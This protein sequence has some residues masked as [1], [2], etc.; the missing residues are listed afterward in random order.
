MR[1][2]VFCC[3]VEGS[4][5][6]RTEAVEALVLEVIDR[7]AREGVARAELE[8]V[9]HQLELHQREVGGDGFPFGLSLILQALGCA[10]HYADPLQVLD[11]DPVLA[12]LRERIADP[13]YIRGLARRLLLDNTHRITLT[14]RPDTGLSAQRREREKAELAALRERLDESAREQLLARAEALKARQA[15]VDD[16]DVLPRVTLADVPQTL[17]QLPYQ[18]Q[19]AGGLR[20][21]S[22]EQGTNGLVY[23]QLVT[24][25]PA[26]SDADWELLSHYTSLA[27]ELGVGG[28]GYLET[29]QRQSAT[30]GGIQLA[31]SL[32]GSVEDEQ[33]VQGYLV[34]SS[35]ALLRNAEAQQALMYDTREQ[36]NFGEFGRI[37]ELISQRRARR[38]A[39]ITGNGHSLAMLAACAGMSPLAAL[40]HESNGLAGTRR[41]RELDRQ[42]QDESGREAFSAALE[43]L[44][45]QLNAATPE[46]LTVSEPGT[47][48]PL[49]E[50]AAGFW[51][52]KAD[53]LND[54][55]LALPALRESRRECWLVNTQVNFC[56]RAYPTVP[57]GH[58][59]A[60]ALTVLGGYLR[61]GFLH[62]A[63][64]EQGGAYGG[65]AGQ[66]SLV[67]AFRFFSY[68]D[69]RL[70]ETLQDFDESVRWLV[71]EK[72]DPHALEEAILGVIA[73]LDKPASPAGEAKQDFYN[74]RFGRSH[75][76][77]M[78]FRR[79]VLAVSLDDLRRVAQQ[80]LVP[81]RS[82]TAV[83]TSARDSEAARRM[84]SEYGLSLR[85]L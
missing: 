64:R 65:G 59:D 22:Y 30:V 66:D 33:Q 9:L 25:L 39:A 54:P 83:L 53:T 12:T 78:A 67:A 41:L 1:E 26:L 2:L 35:K 32:R 68:R 28:K 74:R 8:A 61:N 38:D 23:Q 18:E 40:Q 69:P 19:Q 75:E 17:P 36:I 58:A 11:L 20:V 76:Q 62:R 60:A 4:E 27:S 21:T 72:Q 46:L 50:S 7:V 44:H 79:A 71:E 14:L 29:Q 48:A 16:P 77:R 49:L 24:P 34:L 31:T 80:Y 85:E 63:I 15:A 51:P 82:S 5:A 52:N 3:G 42:L 6:E 13:D 47:V 10:T 56:A 55:G 81:E 70:D 84:E 45:V 73:S 43:R 37:A 57:V